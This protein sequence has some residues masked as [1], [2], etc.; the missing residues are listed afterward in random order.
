[1]THVRISPYYPQSNGKIERWHKT[2]KPDALRP[3]RPGNLKEAHQLMER[4][5][6]YYNRTCMHSTIRYIAPMGFMDGKAKQIWSERDR[7]LE[8]ARELRHQ[9]RAYNVPA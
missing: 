1:M 5:V 8:E 7:K 9:R 2:M 6:A 3:G 4:F